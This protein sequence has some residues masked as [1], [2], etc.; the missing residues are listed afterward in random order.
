MGG[1][2]S[3][4]NLQIIRM[5]LTRGFE[6]RQLLR[7]IRRQPG[8]CAVII[9]SAAV[10]SSIRLTFSIPVAC[11]EIEQVSERGYQIDAKA[12][13]AYRRRGQHHPSR[14]PPASR[15]GNDKDAGRCQDRFR[16]ILIQ[17]AS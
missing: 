2:T 4:Q 3:V 12:Q 10:I 7:K 6:R 15:V 1:T 11:S 5:S 13:H 9:D 8:C 17:N 14:F 16:P